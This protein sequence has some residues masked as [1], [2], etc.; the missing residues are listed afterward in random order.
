LWLE[1]VLATVVL[2]TVG[3]LTGKATDPILT[4]G[5]LGCVQWAILRRYLGNV[6]WWIPATWIGAAVGTSIVGSLPGTPAVHWGVIWLF[7]GLGQWY[8]LKQWHRSAVW[9]ILTNAV[10][11]GTSVAIANTIAQQVPTT[12]GIFGIVL[13]TIFGVVTG[14]VLV[15]LLRR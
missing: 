9:W 7:V 5:F 6:V 10:A 14:T 11:A 2:G 8:L 15:Q 3:G 13:G 12:V 1:W 4:L